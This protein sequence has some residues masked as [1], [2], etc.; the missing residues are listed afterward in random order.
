M[1]WKLLP[2]WLRIVLTV[3]SP[4]IMIVVV[5]AFAFTSYAIMDHFHRHHF[6]KPKVVERITGTTFPE[7]TIDKYKE[8]CFS[9]LCWYETS[10]EFDNVP[11]SSFYRELEKHGNYYFEENDSLMTYSFRKSYYYYTTADIIVNGA[12]YYGNAYITIKEGSKFFT[13]S[14]WERPVNL[15]KKK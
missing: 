5:M 6:T 8:G 15:F 11:D 13:V 14:L 9:T 10:L 1:K 2:K 4:L 3:F 12:A 7:Y